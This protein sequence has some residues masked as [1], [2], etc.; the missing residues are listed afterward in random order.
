MPHDVTNNILTYRCNTDHINSNV[1]TIS[2]CKVFKNYTY[3][4]ALGKTTHKFKVFLCIYFCAC[5]TIMI[6]KVLFCMIHIY[7]L[8]GTSHKTLTQSRRV[9]VSCEAKKKWHACKNSGTPYHY[10]ELF[11]WMVGLNF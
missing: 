7:M 9:V 8:Q 10:S 1:W 3:F 5:S 6:L 4:V 2:Y 11:T